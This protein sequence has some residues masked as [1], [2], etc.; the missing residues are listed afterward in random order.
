MKDLKIGDEVDY[1]P[2]EITAGGSGMGAGAARKPAAEGFNV[3]ILSSSR[4]F[5]DQYVAENIRTNNVLPGFIDSLPERIG[6]ATCRLTFV[7]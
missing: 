2:T 4:L 1:D 3:A 5:A 7:A 6:I